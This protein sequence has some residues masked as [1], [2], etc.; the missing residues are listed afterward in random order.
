MKVC[1]RV[2]AGLTL[3]LSTVGLL[4]SLAAGVGVWIVKERVT[5]RATHVAGGVEGAL[6]LA[7]QSLDQVNASLAGAAKRLKS[8]KEEQRKLAEDRPP[9]HA[10]RMVMARTVQQQVA[11]DLG[12]AHEK[13][14]TVAQAVV[15]ANSVLEDVGNFPFLATSG[16]DVER[17]SEMNR[18]LSQ[19]ESSAWMLTRLLGEPEADPDADAELS[20]IE[21][22]LQS[23]QRLIA[24][25]AS[26]LKEFRQQTEELKA[27]TFAWITPAAIIISCVCFWI[28]LSQVSLFC[29]AWSWTWRSG[30]SSVR[31]C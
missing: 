16:L 30:K 29:H 24:D 31:P 20:R 27:R 7:D 13:L 2:L 8:A 1:K 28:A 22:V 25:Y 21:Q 3:L 19:V 6:D 5:E 4:I 18:S 11:P 23:L 10:L 12:N 15:V 17:L 14:H 26:R 9:G